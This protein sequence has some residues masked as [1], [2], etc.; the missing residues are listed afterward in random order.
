MVVLAGTIANGT[1]ITDNSIDVFYELPEWIINKIY[2]VISNYLIVGTEF[3]VF[4]YDGASQNV[5]L[6][7]VKEQTRLKINSYGNT[8]LTTDKGFR[9]Q[10]DLL[11]DTE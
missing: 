11:I 1:T 4:A 5:S 6:V 10:F 9:W 3:K 2:P 8:V 7:F